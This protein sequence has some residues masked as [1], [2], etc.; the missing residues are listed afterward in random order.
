VIKF[1]MTAAIAGLILMPAMPNLAYAADATGIVKQMA[2]KHGVPQSFAIRVARVESGVKC[3]RI[4]RAG[5]RGP[6]QILPR[7]AAGLGYRNIR[8]ASCATQ[9]SAGMKH[10]AICYRGARGN[11]FRAAAC[12][13]GGF[14]VLKWRRIPKSIQAYARKVARS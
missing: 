5:E 1:V 8:K 12:H 11:Q 6:L 2:R 14:G 3:G 9:T 7:T 10:L 4:G 13:N